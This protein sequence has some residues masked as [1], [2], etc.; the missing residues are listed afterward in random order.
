MASIREG[1]EQPSPTY[2]RAAIRDV[3]RNCIYGVDL[4]PLAVELCKVALWLEAHNPNEPLNFLDHHIKNGNAIV[5]LAHFEELENGIATEAF[6]TLPGDDKELAATL[7]K[8]N[9]AERK[10]KGQLGTYDL[11]KV[12]DSLKGLR[13]EFANFTSLPEGTPEEIAAK[14]AAYQKLT[15]GAKWWRLK[16]LSDLQVAQFFIPKTVEYKEGLTTD[17]QYRTYLN[18][19]TQIL[20]RGASLA[21]AQQKKFFHWFLEFPEVFAKG[22]FD[23]ILGNPPFLGGQYIS[24]D[25][26]ID[27]AEYL[28]LNYAP[29]KSV[30]LVTYFFRRIFNLLSNNRFASLISTKQ[31]LKV[32]QEK[33]D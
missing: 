16:S 19:G 4:N 28:K 7:R 8:K 31:L 21:K 33:E 14:A 2:Y 18:S 24:G 23:C 17:K 29:I 6:K 3:I 30:D 32:L 15:K 10:T 11:S 5:G 1:A 12:D 26:G 25:Y 9:E 20:D 22:G 27:F 13:K